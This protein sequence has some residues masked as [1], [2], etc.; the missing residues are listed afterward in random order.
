M[1]HLN[2]GKL[3]NPEFIS[4]VENVI[5]N[6]SR[7]SLP[8]EFYIIKIDNW[9]DYKWLNFSGT[10]LHEVSVWNSDQ[11]SIP[12]FH[13]NRV[14]D[15][16]HY[17]NQDG[18]FEKTENNFALHIHQQSSDN[19]RRKMSDICQDGLFVWYSDNTELNGI[20]SVMIYK[21]NDNECYGFYTSLDRNKNWNPIKTKGVNMNNMITML[22][23]KEITKK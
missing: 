10:I 22:N 19:L 23:K 13:P 1:I 2:I 11:V 21:V 20:G 3:D 4:K 14:L 6:Q 12:P 5:K 7:N 16:I 8:K 17:I 9:F 15:I 18:T